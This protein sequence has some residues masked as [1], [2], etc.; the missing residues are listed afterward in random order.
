M[1]DVA[2]FDVVDDIFGD[3]GGMVGDALEIARY[4]QQVKGPRDRLRILDHEGEELRVQ[5]SPTGIS[6]VYQCESCETDIE[7]IVNDDNTIEM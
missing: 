5:L 7:L 6:A 3:V 1:P 2:A 4:E